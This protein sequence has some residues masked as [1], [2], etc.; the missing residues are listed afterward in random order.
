MSLRT[1][2]EWHNQANSLMSNAYGTQVQALKQSEE[3]QKSHMDT[4]NSNLAMY[5]ELHGKLEGKVQTTHR[6]I[7]KLE[8]RS[9]SMDDAVTK[10]T[11]SLAQLEVAYSGKAMPIK[12]CAWRMEQ[13]QKRPL[14]EHVRDQVEIAL[15]D[16]R[17]ALAETQKKLQEA[18]V[19]TKNMIAVLI[20]QSEALGGNIDQKMQALSVDELCLRTTHRSWNASAGSRTPNSR[21]ST[22]ATP[23]RTGS[24][25]AVE[26][27]N[28][29]EIRRQQDARNA[30]VQARR[31]EEAAAELRQENELL[32]NRC[33]KLAKDALVMTEKHLNQR[34]VEVR[35][36]R[37]RLENELQ[38]TQRKVDHTK[39]TIYET[40]SQIHAIQEPIALCSTHAS[41]RKQRS[42]REQ[43]MD[44]VET[45]LENQ[46]QKLMRSTEELRSHRQ[47]EK[48]VLTALGEQVERLKED[49]RD[50]TVAL[51]IDES[52]IRRA[53]ESAPGS[54]KGAPKSARG[55]I[56]RAGA[57][58][59]DASG[60]PHLGMGMGMG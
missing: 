36:M 57:K 14:R 40:Q 48:N 18:M 55:K 59:M 9:K 21:M 10:T 4:T 20:D 23:R 49:L 37:K 19:V 32:V 27:S 25:T 51:Q 29:N 60:L 35:Q 6:I 44:P 43:I 56:A 45:Q 53:S 58:M 39:S 52:C 31:R 26:E 16:E 54:S 17:A 41:W 7:D 47:N 22:A 8:A 24:M 42:D 46:K 15:D 33:A 2:S 38:E 12:M 3:S 5:K 28:R 1:P 13:R 34:V 11:K 50:K 30:D